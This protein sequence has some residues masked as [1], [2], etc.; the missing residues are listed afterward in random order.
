[1]AQSCPTSASFG[2]VIGDGEGIP[3]GEVEG[4]DER[5]LIE[6]YRSMVTPEPTTNGRSSTTARA[7]SAPTRSS[8]T[9]RPCRPACTRSSAATDLPELPRVRDWAP[10]RDAGLDRPLVVARPSRRM[11]E[12]A[13]LQR[14]LDL[15]PDRDPRPARGGPGLGEEAP[16]RAGG[17]DRALR[18]RRDVRGLVPRGRELRRRDEG[19][20]DPLLQQQPVGDLDAAL[21][22]DGRGDAGRQGRLADAGRTR[23]GGDVLAVYEAT[24]AAVERARSGEGPSLPR[25]SPMGGAAMRLPTTRRRTSTSSASRRRNGT[26]AWAG[27]SATCSASAS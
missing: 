11:V 25:R 12:P 18:R 5:D 13:R 24:R 4:I 9:T 6:L 14:R 19:A 10:A 17:C 15:R 3:D 7:G 21:G 1:M 2:R 8:G 16:R 23:D 20:G 22:A 27:T 26:S